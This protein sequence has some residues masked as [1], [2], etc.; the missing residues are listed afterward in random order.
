MSLRIE[1][2]DRQSAARAG[3]FQ[4]PHGPV[5][6]PVF[7]PVGTQ[8]TVK[9]MA[10]WDLETVGAQIIL[11]N[12]YHLNLR[13]GPALIRKFGGLHRFIG[14]DRAILTDSGGF[15]IFSM[16]GVTRVVD[17]GVHFVSHLDGGRHF[18][19]PED[20][21]GIQKDLG[22][23][24]MMVLDHLLPAGSGDA[25][26]RE[27]MERTIAWAARC[28]AAHRDNPTPQLLFAIQQGGFDDL[29]RAECADRLTLHPFDG[30]AVG[31]LSVGE[32]KE[33]MYRTAA[34]SVDHLPADRPRYIMG[35]GT[36]ADLL[37]FIS[38]G[39]D[40]FDCVLPT[41]N[42][43]TG[44]LYTR[45][46]PIVIKNARYRD[47]EGP[48]DPECACEVCRIFSRAYLRH[49]FVAREILGVMLNT[50]H[51]LHFYLTLIAEAR[52]RILEGTFASWRDGWLSRYGDDSDASA[53]ESS[54]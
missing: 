28:L 15:Q 2:I 53:D 25:A 44:L 3:V 5:R 30:F 48:I 42:A 54:S 29:L 51:N 36:P 47:D 50:R 16:Q 9:G 19:S 26:V 4:T 40:M 38:L 45:S 14:W 22:T 17:E 23:D 21:V 32:E 37:T 33:I 43:R 13:P 7:M 11:G 1:S 46:G 18:M 12:T 52:A 49:L 10:P 35:V 8:G 31:G 34:A 41:R 20:C 39:Y 24:I 6:T 27:A